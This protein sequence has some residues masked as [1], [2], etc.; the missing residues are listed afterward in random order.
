MVN[1]ELEHKIM[2]Q[3]H[4]DARL[5]NADVHAEV[6][7]GRVVLRGT[8]SSLAQLKAAE[9]TVS[10]VQGVASVDNRL[11]ILHGLE[12]EDEQIEAA[13]S[14]RLEADREIDENAI[15]FTVEEG[16][17]TLLGSVDSYWKKERVEEIASHT[18]GT[19]LVVNKLE[20]VP[21]SSPDDRRI[22]EEVRLALERMNAADTRHVTVMVDHGT[23]TLTGKVPH[24]NSYNS[25]EF[26][27]RHTR[28]VTEV[29]NDLLMI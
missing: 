2:E 12:K 1:E 15:Q 14:S 25:A 23:V 7:G 28:G 19:A 13:L 24:W 11:R 5:E 17:I 4:W 9:L 21:S 6:S 27:A 8:V 22:A 10:S 18:S 3:L 20:V 29:K 16:L 26:A